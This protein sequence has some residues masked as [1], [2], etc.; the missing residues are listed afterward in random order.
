MIATS[1]DLTGHHAGRSVSVNMS[2]RFAKKKSAFATTITYKARSGVVC[3]LRPVEALIDAFTCTD[4][5]VT[6]TARLRRKGRRKSRSRQLR[7]HPAVDRSNAGADAS[8]IKR[9]RPVVVKRR[10]YIRIRP[11]GALTIWAAWRS[12]PKQGREREREDDRGLSIFY[13][14]SCRYDAALFR[15]M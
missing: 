3:F 11:Y 8:D 5:H 13:C 9:S 2:S 12:D 14:M 4:I 6:R 15:C 10:D 1:A 7:R